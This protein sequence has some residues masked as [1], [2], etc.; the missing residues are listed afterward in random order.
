MVGCFGVSV[1]QYFCDNAAEPHKLQGYPQDIGGCELLGSNLCGQAQETT[2]IGP[3]TY[4]QPRLEHFDEVNIRT[5][6]SNA[7]CVISGMG[8]T[9]IMTCTLI[10]DHGDGISKPVDQKEIGYLAVNSMIGRI[11]D[12]FTI[13]PRHNLKKCAKGNLR[14][15]A[16]SGPP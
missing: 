14:K 3:L 4:G 13:L 16:M 15:Q 1:K 5:L 12:L 6:A 10:L 7:L 2:Q 8:R 9:L 11:S